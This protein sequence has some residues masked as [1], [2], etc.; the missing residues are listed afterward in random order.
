[1]ALVQKVAA[2]A[3]GQYLTAHAGRTVDSSALVSAYEQDFGAGTGG[4]LVLNCT[5]L[6]GSS[7]LL[8]V[9]MHLP[10]PPPAASAL[11]S[12]V[13]S[14]GDRGNCP[15]SFLLDPVPSR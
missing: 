5:N 12:S 9:R 15:S 7:A 13:L 1:A 14:T 2:T 11:T 10:N 6:R 4:N 8:E 3:F